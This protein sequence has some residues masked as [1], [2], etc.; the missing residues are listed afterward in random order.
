MTDQFWKDHLVKHGLKDVRQIDEYVD[1]L[2]SEMSM[3]TIHRLTC[4]LNT[5]QL[6]K[7]RFL[8]LK[9]QNK[10]SKRKSKKRT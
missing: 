6:I 5:L 8:T 4:L 9:K 7:R 1:K 2:A 10:K 3:M